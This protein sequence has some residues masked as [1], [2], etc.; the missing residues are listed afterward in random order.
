[1]DYDKFLTRGL[2]GTSLWSTIRY[3]C[4]THDQML[5]EMRTRQKELVT[6]A[7]MASG[8][9]PVKASGIDAVQEGLLRDIRFLQEMAWRLYMFGR[10]SLF[11]P[12]PGNDGEYKKRMR[13]DPA[14]WLKLS[15]C[16]MAYG[17]P[18]CNYP[19]NAKDPKKNPCQQPKCKHSGAVKAEKW[20][21]HNMRA[22]WNR[23]IL[24]RY[25]Y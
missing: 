11:S 2:D 18:G 9:G 15:Q 22:Y 13:T 20:L 21:K 7:R 23:E 8:F 5:T 14:F 19:S 1:M 12:L 4:T 17:P 10:R 3:K 16:K 24:N 6:Y 25:K